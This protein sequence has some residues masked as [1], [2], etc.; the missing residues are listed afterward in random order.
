MSYLKNNES[1]DTAIYF[2]KYHH[3][4]QRCIDNASILEV[5]F[6]SYVVAVYSL[7]GG[8]SIKFVLQSCHDFCKSI[9]GLTKWRMV[10]DSWVELLWQDVLMSI[11]YVHR[12]YSLFQN[13]TS[14]EEL[15][16]SLEQVQELLQTSDCLLPSETDIL[17]LPL[18]M[19]TEE[20]CLKVISLSIYLQFYLDHL[21]FRSS[22]NVNPEISNKL[23]DGL[24]SIVER[25]NRLVAHLSPI[26]DYIYHAY[27]F[28]LDHHTGAT[29]AFLH[30]PNVQ[31][32]GLKVTGDAEERDTAPA[33]L[34]AFARLLKNML[35]R[36]ADENEKFISEIHHSAIAMCRLC[37]SFPDRSPM[38]TLL[39]KRSLF[40]AGLILT[41]SR[42]YAGSVLMLS[43]D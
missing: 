2:A 8:W 16:E 4:A 10:S 19:T 12:D 20:I 43:T 22:Y 25:I 5:A 6:A 14:R 21:L 3:E 7:I 29:N 33:L 38:V 17:N 37:A 41:E 35:E 28:G 27:N 15:I 9:V 18:S 32:H 24:Y 26:G 34:Y 11:Y 39:A 30:F 1:R 42:F 13:F 23:T 31:P 40:W 36:T